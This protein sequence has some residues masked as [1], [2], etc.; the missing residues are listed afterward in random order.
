MTTIS[1]F[2]YVGH[3]RRVMG[4]NGMPKGP[5]GDHRDSKRHPKWSQWKLIVR[6][7]GPNAVV[8]GLNWEV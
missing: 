2:G 1:Q 5:I 7:V 6:A 3:L 4:P 8:K